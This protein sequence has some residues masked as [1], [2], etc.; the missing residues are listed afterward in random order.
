ME[1]NNK[2]YEYNIPKYSVYA[3]HMEHLASYLGFLKLAFKLKLNLDYVEHSNNIKFELHKP[4][5]FGESKVTA[6]DYRL[7]IYYAHELIFNQTV[8]EFKDGVT[9]LL[10]GTGDIDDFC[11]FNDLTGLYYM[12]AIAGLGTAF[13]SLGIWI[14]ILLCKNKP[15]LDELPLLNNN[16][17]PNT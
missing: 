2:L 14:L 3:G 12:I 16:P 11:G 13:V 8:K 4:K 7:Y 5:K 17:N 6:K 10:V 15:N 1:N 9:P